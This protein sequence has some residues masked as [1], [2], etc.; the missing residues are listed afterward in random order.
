MRFVIDGPPAT[1]KTS[2]RIVRNKSTG[3]MLIIASKL[4]KGWTAGAVAQLRAQS[5]GCRSLAVRAPKKILKLNPNAVRMV[6][7]TG[8]VN[9][10]AL[11]YRTRDV[12]DAVNFYQAVADALQEADVVANDRQ[13]MSWNG[14]DLL[15]DRHRP[16][17]EIEL[18][19]REQAPVLSKSEM[20]RRAA[21]EP[22]T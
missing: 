3:K 10:R 11:F 20:K 19:P 4:T 15:I 1:K 22:S 5:V 18:T 17:V 8:P 12:G 21:L 16:R 9:C 14:S 6:A 7:W 2:Q 13:I